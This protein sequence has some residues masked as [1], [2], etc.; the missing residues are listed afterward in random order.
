MAR[1]IYDDLEMDEYDLGLGIKEILKLNQTRMTV[2]QIQEA[3]RRTKIEEVGGAKYVVEAS[4]KEIR[5]LLET[6]LVLGGEEVVQVGENLFQFQAE[7]AC[8]V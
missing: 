8:P 5:E 7:V 6:W 3:L 2:E 1:M 4:V